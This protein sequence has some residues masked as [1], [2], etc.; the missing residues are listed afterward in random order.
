[1]PDKL[2]YEIYCKKC[3]RS[4][5][6]VTANEYASWLVDAYDE[7]LCF[8]CDP[9][10]SADSHVNF[11][12]Y[13]EKSATLMTGSEWFI[14]NGSVLPRESSHERTHEHTRA[15]GL[16]SYTKLNRISKNREL[17]ASG[18]E[19]RV[20]PQCKGLGCYPEFWEKSACSVC[21]GVGTV[22]SAI[23]IP[24]WILGLESGN[25]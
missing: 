17:L 12:I 24:T 25:E 18:E 14:A 16:S 3:H 7:G 22:V 6:E 8:D 10:K 15:R 13:D 11:M 19:T 20:C 2:G 5:G 4:M 9:L 21:D 23:V 1:M